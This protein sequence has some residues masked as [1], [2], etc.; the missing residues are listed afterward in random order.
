MLTPFRLTPL[1]LFHT[2]LSLVTLGLAFAALFRDRAVSP[3]TTLG[4]WYLATLIVTTLTGLPI[5][6]SGRVGPPHVLGV[7]ILV[8]LALAWVAGRAARPSSLAAYVEALA[9]SFTVFL[10]MIPTVTETLTRVPPGAPLV[11]SPE[12]PLFGPLYGVLFAVF[13]V[14][15]WLQVRAMRRDA[16]ARDVARVA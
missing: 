14:G 6:R 2:L 12:A 11:A 16:P 9:Y 5:F 7:V 1:G 4:R 10:Y 15:A 3:R 8:V 13:L